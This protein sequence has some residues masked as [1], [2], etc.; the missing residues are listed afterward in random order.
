MHLNQG[1]GEGFGIGNESPGDFVTGLSVGVD[2]EEGTSG[3]NRW[4]E[5]AGPA[6]VPFEVTGAVVVFGLVLR[7][8]DPVDFHDFGGEDVLVDW[9]S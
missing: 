3:R 6:F 1:F 7:I 5:G 4:D 2:G 8:G 9:E